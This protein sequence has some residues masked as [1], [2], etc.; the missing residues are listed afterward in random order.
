MSAENLV[1]VAK[2]Y[3][4]RAAEEA[5]VPEA[6]REFTYG[7]CHS[8]PDPGNDYKV[9]AINTGAGDKIV[10]N[11]FGKWMAGGRAPLNSFHMNCWEMVFFLAF[12]AECITEER[13]REIHAEAARAGKQGRSGDAY[14]AVI[15]AA[16][17][18]D[19]GR[20]ITDK[21]DFEPGSIL[22]FEDAGEHKLERMKHVALGIDAPKILNHNLS[23]YEA[24]GSA[25]SYMNK[26]NLTLCNIGDVYYWGNPGYE[27]R[28]APYPFG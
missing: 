9:K 24:S 3:A 15:G 23:D 28:A 22:F 14:Y 12:R 20:V 1:L 4:E 21:T 13:L 16:L 10:S 27:T 8:G 5:N 6:Y 19:D 2:Q 11:D 7:W 18:Y 26:A 25:Y 17:G